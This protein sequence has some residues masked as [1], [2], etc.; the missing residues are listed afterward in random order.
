MKLGNLILEGKKRAEADGHRM[1]RFRRFNNVFAEGTCKV[2]Y[3]TVYV[4][5]P[6]EIRGRAVSF[7]CRGEAP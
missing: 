5:R 3:M 2:C 1:R 4:E 6:K 7:S